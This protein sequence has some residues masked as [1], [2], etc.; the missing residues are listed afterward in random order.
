MLRYQY[1]F[2]QLVR[3]ELR[4]KYKGSALGVIWYLI[5]PLVLMAVYGVMLGPLLKAVNVPDYPIFILV[6]LLVWLFF[7]QALLAAST[8]LV[9][10]SALVSKVRFPRESI[11]AAA[12]AVQLVPLFAMLV[13]LLPLARALRGGVHPSLVLVMP[14][15]VCL[16]G[17]TLGL[18]LIVSALHAYFRD[19]QPV[20]T[21]VLLPL[22][23]VSGVLFRIQTLPGLH[24][25]H[26]AEPLLRWGNP[27]A[28]FIEAM[29]EVV[30][31]GR[32]PA[33]AT[34]LYVGVAAVISFAAGAA[35]FRR[36]DREL[37]VVL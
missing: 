27:V 25:H 4:Q 5:N 16:L 36:L 12:V 30:Y 33:A 2:T 11:P 8:S 18:S 31:D 9:E 35:V 14:L 29:R 23:F 24:S 37:A 6:G 17:F 34:L 15:I 22:F 13:V 19:V 32:S 10:Q 1:L 26:W 20:L 3:R 7:S 21:A 28:P